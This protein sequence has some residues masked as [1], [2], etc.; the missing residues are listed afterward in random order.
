M[1]CSCVCVKNTLS[2]GLKQ[3]LILDNTIKHL[4]ASH[5]KIINTSI[6][7][8]TDMVLSALEK[9]RTLILTKILRDE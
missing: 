6:F 8:V 2:S 7:F 9:L 4:N 1:L 5:K 3:E